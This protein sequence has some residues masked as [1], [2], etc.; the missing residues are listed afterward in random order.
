MLANAFPLVTSIV[1]ILLFKEFRGASR[2]T[3]GLLGLKF[4]LYVVAVA[5]L[6][7]SASS[8]A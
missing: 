6:A 4:A 1:G 8:R 3:K 7:S 5:L 2:G